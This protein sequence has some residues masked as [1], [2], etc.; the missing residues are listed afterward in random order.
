MMLEVSI[1]DSIAVRMDDGIE[2]QRLTPEQTEDYLIRMSRTA[3]KTY[4]DIPASS[5][6]AP[7]GDEDD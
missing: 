2:D 3:V 5:M 4:A 7:E 1:G 6:V